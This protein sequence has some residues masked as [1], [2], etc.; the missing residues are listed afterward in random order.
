MFEVSTLRAAVDRGDLADGALACAYVASRMHH[1]AGARF[2]Q[3]RRRTPL[4]SRN[5][6][7]PVVLFAEHRIFSIGEPVAQ[8]LVAWANDQRDVELRRDVPTARSLVS[9]QARGRRCV[10]LLGPILAEQPDDRG[11]D[12]AV[13][14]LCHLE[15]F[16][17]PEHHRG[18][19]GFFAAVEHAFE[20]PSWHVLDARLDDEFR[21]AVEH[22]VADMNGSAIFL[23]AALK[24]KLRMAS[25][26]RLARERGVPARTEGPLD[27][28]ELALFHDDLA[29]LLDALAIHGDVRAAAGTISTKRDAKEDAMVLLRHFEE[30]AG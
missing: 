30:R 29:L 12:F 19:R 20:H 4:A 16:V 10:S 11:L 9:L 28:G 8:A 14:D 18:Q 23:F 25:R 27:D 1:R 22:V 17:D 3:G 26:R 7:P 5:E 21:T 24:M 15:K 13:H 6:A 2:V